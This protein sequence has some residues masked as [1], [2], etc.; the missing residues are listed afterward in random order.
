MRSRAWKCQRWKISAGG[1]GT[2]STAGFPVSI[3]L[4]CAAAVAARVAYTTDVSATHLCNRP[5]PIRLSRM[6]QAD[7]LHVSVSLFSVPQIHPTAIGQKVEI[8]VEHFRRHV[9][10]T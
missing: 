5:P 10:G 8:I 4:S 2:G 1:S 9:K 6:P 3:G 7:R